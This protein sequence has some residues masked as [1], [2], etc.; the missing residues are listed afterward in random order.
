M[1]LIFN[2][3]NTS[4]LMPYRKFISYFS[5]RVKFPFK[6]LSNLFLAIT[7]FLY[8]YFYGC[9]FIFFAIC[10]QPF[11]CSPEFFH[12]NIQ[13]S[14]FIIHHCFLQ[15]FLQASFRNLYI[16]KI[17]NLMVNIFLYFTVVYSVIRNISF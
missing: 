14:I 5:Q 13:L 6:Y 11:Q 15:E 8:Q 3:N 16:L 7:H 2:F 12:R 9:L 10:F 17:N 1:P 4:F